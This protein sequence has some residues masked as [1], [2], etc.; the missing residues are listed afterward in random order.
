MIIVTLKTNLD[1]EVEAT[2]FKFV[3][4]ELILKN[5]NKVAAVYLR[6]NVRKVTPVYPKSE[7]K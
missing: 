4:T 7:S 6:E 2:S 1:D 3:E 5:G